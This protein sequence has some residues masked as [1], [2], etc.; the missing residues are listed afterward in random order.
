[1]KMLKDK[2]LIQMCEEM[3]F[4]ITGKY[5]PKNQQCETQGNPDWQIAMYYFRKLNNK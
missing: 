1:M 5:I 3:L 2:E 4:Q